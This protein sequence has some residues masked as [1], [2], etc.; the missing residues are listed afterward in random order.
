MNPYMLFLWQSSVDTDTISLISKFSIMGLCLWVMHVLHTVSYCCIGTHYAPIRI[1]ADVK[2][3][4]VFG[5]KWRGWGCGSRNGPLK[6]TS[7]M[8]S[9]ATNQIPRPRLKFLLFSLRNNTV[10]HTLHSWNTNEQWTISLWRSIKF[11]FQLKMLYDI[12]KMLSLKT[13]SIWTKQCVKHFNIFINTYKA[14]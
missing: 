3:S 6:Q 8:N 10:T 12:W 14:Y 1:S 7:S 9:A 11:L 13:T 2:I 5:E 4:N